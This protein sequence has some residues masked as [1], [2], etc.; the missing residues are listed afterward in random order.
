M[1]YNKLQIILLLICSSWGSFALPSKIQ[2]QN[3]FLRTGNDMMPFCCFLDS[4]KRA[5]AENKMA[6][7]T[8]NKK[9]I[10]FSLLNLGKWYADKSNFAKANYYIQK[11]NITAISLSDKTYEIMALKALIPLYELEKKYIEIIQAQN[12]LLLI[13]DQFYLSEKEKL[14]KRLEMQFKSNQNNNNLG[15]ISNEEEAKLPSNFR[16]LIGIILIG[17][18]LIF[19]VVF[20]LLNNSKKRGKKML[21]LKENLFKTLEIQ[22]K[23]EK[24]KFENELEQKEN[25]LTCISLQ[26]L[27]KNELL[28]EIKAKIENKEPLPAQQLLKMVNQHFEQN[29]IW[30]D[31]DLY[32]ESINKHFHMRLKETYSKINS[33]DLKICALIKLNMSVKEMAFILNISP[34]SVKTARYRLRKKLQ[35]TAE[36]KLTDFILSI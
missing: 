14:G 6:D 8:Q 35:L 5:Q 28:N 23:K 19:I 9:V 36:Q 21:D 27:K 30:N 3:N 33:N 29:K 1:I 22:N 4:S 11:A 2:V 15:L 12:R 31:F 13:K 25:Q 26:V 7:F 34:D 32:F 24:A 18:T 20:Y 17:I 16:V 10:F